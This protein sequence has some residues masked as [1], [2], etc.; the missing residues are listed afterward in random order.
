MSVYRRKYKIKGKGGTS[1]FYTVEFTGPDGKLVRKSTRCTNRRAAEAVE[2]EL[3]HT[4]EGSHAG[5]VDP[6]EARRAIDDQIDEFVG[7]LLTDLHRDADYCRIT[8]SRLR[9]LSREAGWRRLADVSLGTFESWRRAQKEVTRH[10]RKPKPKTVN[11]FLDS[12][13]RFLNWAKKRGKVKF[14]P[15]LD[16]D[17]AQVDDNR[18]YRRAGT[19]EEFGKLIATTAGDRNRFYRWALYVPLRRRTHGELTWADVCERAKPPYVAIRA[20]TI[21]DKKHIALPLRADVAMMMADWRMEL[22][23]RPSDLVFPNLP[24][25][26]EIEADLKAAG[27]VFK[28]EA[29]KHR[30]DLHAFR[31]TAVRWMR[32]AGV[33]IE[34]AAAIL[35]HKD[36]RTTKRYYDEEPDP[37][38]LNVVEKMPGLPESGGR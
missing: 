15:L 20:E 14:N 19:L 18:N 17:K 12:A 33:P 6:K 16:A 29:G 8:K 35:Q 5:L 23:P 38:S 25:I 24:T 1:R 27:V 13:R 21:K 36:I 11:Q 26:R 7:H 31:K 37:R 32:Q 10:G 3:R 28:D 2:V 34:D 30:L 4:A 22:N 9:L